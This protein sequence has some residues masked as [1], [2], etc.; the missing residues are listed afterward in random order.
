MA[1][2]DYVSCEE[3]G[4]RLFYDGDRRARDYMIGENLPPSVT[5]SK[6]VSKLK[7]KIE[8]L[9]KFDKRRH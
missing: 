1:G 3:C 7:K 9:K 4:K 2:L 6:C 5:C 8:R